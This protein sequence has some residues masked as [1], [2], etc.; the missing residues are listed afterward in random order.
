MAM[1]Q[2]FIFSLC[3][4]RIASDPLELLSDEEKEYVGKMHILD[5]PIN[6]RHVVRDVTLHGNA[7]WVLLCIL[8]NIKYHFH[9]C[10]K[11]RFVSIFVRKTRQ[12]ILWVFEEIL[13]TKYIRFY[14]LKLINDSI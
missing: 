4:F 14:A 7:T 2:I 12:I 5:L 6:A 10:V 8:V 11:K 13:H 3:I 1:L 9:I